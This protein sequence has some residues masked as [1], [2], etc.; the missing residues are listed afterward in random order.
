MITIFKLYQAYDLN[1]YKILHREKFKSTEND[2]LAWWLK[3][4]N[5]FKYEYWKKWL[6]LIFG[7]YML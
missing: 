5:V 1:I 4:L 7:F 6:A 2:K 3:F